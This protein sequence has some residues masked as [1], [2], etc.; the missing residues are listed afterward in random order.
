M[1]QQDDQALRWRFR[2][3]I[4]GS[5]RVAAYPRGRG[6]RAL[7]G[8]S[9]RSCSNALRNCPRRSFSWFRIKRLKEMLLSSSQKNVTAG[10]NATR[11]ERIATTSYLRCSS[12]SS[13]PSPNQQK[14][15]KAANVHGPAIFGQVCNLDQAVNHA[16]PDTA[17]LALMAHKIA[18]LNF[19]DEDGGAH[20]LQTAS[21]KVRPPIC[22]QPT[23]RRAP[24]SRDQIVKSAT[25]LSR[26]T[27]LP[28]SNR[29]ASARNDA[30]QQG[31]GNR[32]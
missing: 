15:G 14:A 12:L 4:P 31:G 27:G 10:I 8:T 28:W 5:D 22:S 16:D 29:H 24:A 20:A 19:A 26:A 2:C 18:G 17:P 11:E 30:M 13:E 9:R 6:R 21:L 32:E 23:N 7:P 25:V 3:D 1:R